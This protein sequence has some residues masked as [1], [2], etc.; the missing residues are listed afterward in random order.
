MKE[1]NEFFKTFFNL[2]NAVTSAKRLVNDETRHITLVLIN[3]STNKQKILQTEKES[4]KDVEIYIEPDLLPH[5][6]KLRQKLRAKVKA[7]EALGNKVFIK[8]HAIKVNDNWLVWNE[9]KGE[10]SPEANIRKQ[11]LRKPQEPAKN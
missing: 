2:D 6:L 5:E 8:G 11:H 10:W 1:A 9:N 3:S 4:L 7:E